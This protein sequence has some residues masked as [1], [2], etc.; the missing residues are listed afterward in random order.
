MFKLLSVAALPFTV[1]SHEESGSIFLCHYH[2]ATIFL[3]FQLNSSNLSAFHVSTGS[4]DPFLKHALSLYWLH[5]PVPK[6]MSQGVSQSQHPPRPASHRSPWVL[7]IAEGICTVQ[8]LQTLVS[9][10][11]VANLPRRCCPAGLLL[12]Q[13]A[14]RA[15]GRRA[16]RSALGG[17]A[18]S[19]LAPQASSSACRQPA[20]E[21]GR[22]PVR[23]PPSLSQAVSRRFLPL[24]HA[25]GRCWASC[26][27]W[28]LCLAHPSPPHALTQGLVAPVRLPSA[29]TAS[30]LPPAAL[31]F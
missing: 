31:S 9:S 2:T 13:T 11:P 28:A 23:L 5:L 19:G 16:A 1:Y 12:G 4:A 27:C 8:G 15:V 10:D 29:S 18:G 22:G 6:V 3:A 30:H 7:E 24:L 20:W 25:A 21:H 14:Q 17:G 26:C